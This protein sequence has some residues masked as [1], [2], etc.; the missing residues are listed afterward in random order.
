[1]PY[2]ARQARLFRAAAAGRSSQMSQAEG[3]RMVRKVK[4]HG[5]KRKKKGTTIL[6]R[7]L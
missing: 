2:S 1:M 6:T 4:Q 3:K 7:G 5:L